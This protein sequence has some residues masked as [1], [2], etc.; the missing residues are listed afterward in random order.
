V[1][2]FIDM[3]DLGDALVR[4]GFADPV[5]DVEHFTLTYPDVMRVLRDLKSIGAHNAEK[6][7]IAGLTGK[8]RFAQFKAAYERRRRDGLIP[9][10]YEV[11]YGHAWAPLQKPTSHRLPGGDVA[12]PLRQIGGRRR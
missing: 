6:Q 10:T 3:H 2:T 12:I 5:M 11:V 9:A 1:H 4:A 8:Q 7:R